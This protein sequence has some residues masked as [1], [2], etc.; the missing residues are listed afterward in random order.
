LDK[1][2]KEKE[3]EE[4]KLKEIKEREY[5]EKFPNGISCTL[6]ESILCFVHFE[7]NFKSKIKS[8]EIYDILSPNKEG[9]K[10]IKYKLKEDTFFV[11]FPFYKN[12]AQKSVYFDIRDKKIK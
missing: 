7:I 2:L 11:V 4:K 9:F 10:F 6:Q 3:N 8:A 12:K 5:A 1:K